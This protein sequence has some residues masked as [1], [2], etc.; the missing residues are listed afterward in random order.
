MEVDPD[1]SGI[2]QLSEVSVTEEEEVQGQVNAYGSPIGANSRVLRRE[3]AIVTASAQPSTSQNINRVVS[4]SLNHL[5]V[6]CQDLQ[7]VIFFGLIE[8][9][10]IRV[11]YALLPVC[12][13]AVVRIPAVEGKVRGTKVVRA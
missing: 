13:F 1:E 2:D 6:L 7:A 3:S 8:F 4:I 10:S 9:F 11:K 12:R 5:C